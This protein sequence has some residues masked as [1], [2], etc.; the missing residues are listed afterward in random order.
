MVTDITNQLFSDFRRC[1]YKAYLRLAGETG[2]HSEFEGMVRKLSQDYR[3]RAIEHILQHYSPNDITMKSIPLTVLMEKKYSFA[4]DVTHSNNDIAIHFDAL[5]ALESSQNMDTPIYIPVLFRYEEKITKDQKSLL[6][7]CA[8][9]LAAQQGFEPPFGRIIHGSR[10][11]SSKILF[12]RLLGE[13]ERVIQQIRE[14]KQADN[15]PPLHLKA[16]CPTCDFGQSCREIVAEKDD[17]S[18]IQ[19][20]KEKEITKLNS[21]GIFTVTQLSYTF[22][23]RKRSRRSNP[24]NIKYHH[25]LKALAIRE[26]R[27]Y[28]A[29]RPELRL[30]GTLVYL[31]VEGIPDRD[32]YYLVG[33][34]IC[35]D[36]SCIQHSFWADDST[37]EE[38]IWHEFLD[39]IAGLND[40]HLLYYGS[41]ETT[42]FKRMKKRYGYASHDRAK[43]DRLIAEAEN[44]L[45]VIY[46]QIYFPTYSNSLKEIASLLG[47]RWSMKDPSGLRC[48]LFRHKWEA[49][50]DTKIKANII[51]YNAEDCE[52]LE[53]VVNTIL[54][55]LPGMCQ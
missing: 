5:M 38:K 42:F 1:E 8:S 29:G 48:L 53:T 2:Y 7:F 9:V 34:R 40:P 27:I 10:F 15:P 24:K 21:R 50:G 45:T 11:S 46:G 33:L 14:L 19:S 13:A 32:F 23:P 4:I 18:L 54:Q 22:R 35:R 43:M 25:S 26:N 28:I 49:T 41:Y 30:S 51:N 39:V 16:H 47:H 12:S 52:A 31:D 20:I 44:V 3:V 6:A 37:E 36:Q 55:L 17:L